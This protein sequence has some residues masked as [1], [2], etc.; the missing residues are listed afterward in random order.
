VPTSYTHGW[1]VGFWLFVEDQAE[2]GTNLLNVVL[3]DNMVISIGLDTKIANICHIY[4]A[5]NPSVA[6]QTSVTNLIALG[7]SLGTN[8]I[9]T[10][11]KFA[12][13]MNSKWFYARCAYSWDYGK[14]YS[15]ISY[16]DTPSPVVTEKAI[17]FETRYKDTALGNHFRKFYWRSSDKMQL[18]VTGG[19]TFAGSKSAFIKNLYV[20]KDMLP[21]TLDIQYL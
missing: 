18:K 14:M 1:T 15:S 5:Q 13:D 7:T 10:T 16:T 21:S 6:T 4:V 3:V 2:I 8:T 19:S 20:F 9:T 17:T 11:A 12:G